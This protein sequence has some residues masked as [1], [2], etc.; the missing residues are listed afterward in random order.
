[1]RGSVRIG[2][3]LQ[4]RPLGYQD[5]RPACLDIQP[6]PGTVQTMGVAQ[7]VTARSVCDVENR[8][9][10]HDALATQEQRQRDLQ[11]VPPPPTHAS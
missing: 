9:K 1:M 3:E 4:L 10:E 8:L 7:P 2:I 11:T 5:H 6:R